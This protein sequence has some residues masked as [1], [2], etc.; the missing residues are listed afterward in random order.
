MT[1]A[2]GR[3][4][5][6]VGDIGERYD[7][8][9]HQRTGDRQSVGREELPREILEEILLEPGIAKDAGKEAHRRQGAHGQDHQDTRVS[10]QERQDAADHTKAQ[11]DERGEPEALLG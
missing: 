7:A 4:Q 6:H 11:S 9:D 1:D 2:F 5:Q 8:Q 3:A 10:R